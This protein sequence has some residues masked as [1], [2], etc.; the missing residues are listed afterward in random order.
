MSW[1]EVSVTLHIL[2]A[3]IWVGGMIFLALVVLPILRQREYRFVAGPLIRG[4]GVRFRWVGWMAVATLVLTGLANL[5]FRGYGWTQ[6]RDGSGWQ[7]WFG[8]TLAAKLILVA[9][10]V[11]ISAVHDLVLGPVAAEQLDTA[12]AQRLRRRAAWMGRVV[13]LFSIAV[14]ALGVILVRG[15]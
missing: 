6:L 12:A 3:C 9:A 13:L 1:Y 5:R 2:A 15:V 4:A 11:V 8:H 14:V 10:V 7:G